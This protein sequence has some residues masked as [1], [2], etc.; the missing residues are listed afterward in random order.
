M[1]G[2]PTGPDRIGFNS[3]KVNTW[4]YVDDQV[5]SAKCERL[6]VSSFSNLYY[7]YILYI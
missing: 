1:V 7:T 5:L 2:V 3:H 6:L 4:K